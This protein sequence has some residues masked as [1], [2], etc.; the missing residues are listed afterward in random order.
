MKNLLDTLILKNE[1][2]G[3]IRPEYLIEDQAV[4]INRVFTKLFFQ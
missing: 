3:N 1:L 2:D 4:V